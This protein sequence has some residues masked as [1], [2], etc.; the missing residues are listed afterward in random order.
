MTS[1]PGETWIVGCGKMAGAMVEGWRRAGV[2]FGNAIAIRPSG[3]PVE[4]VRTLR[5]LPP[6]SPDFILLGIN[7]R[8]ST[9]RP[10]ARIPCRPG[11][12]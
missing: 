12:T 11:A 1:L 10:C 6:G 5:S 7:R 3:T 8:N 2:D 4:G 9:S